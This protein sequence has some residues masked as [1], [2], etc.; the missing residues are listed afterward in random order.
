MCRLVYKLHWPGQ[1]EGTGLLEY[2]AV[3][4]LRDVAHDGVLCIHL[5]K[6][7]PQTVTSG[8]DRPSHTKSHPSGSLSSSQP[9]G[10][11][12]FASSLTFGLIG[13][14]ISFFL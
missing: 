1:R 2:Q 4:S 6:D 14:D 10:P 13:Q 9:E 12:G 3:P 8:V 7:L 5:G 11:P